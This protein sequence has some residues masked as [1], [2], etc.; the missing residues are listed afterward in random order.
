MDR[1]LAD[2]VR[3]RRPH[4]V[5]RFHPGR[6]SAGVGLR[7]GPLPGG[8]AIPGQGPWLLLHLRRARSGDLALSA[9]LKKGLGT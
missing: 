8:V 6:I 1:H 7:P 5:C 2:R 3:V 9:A 4:A